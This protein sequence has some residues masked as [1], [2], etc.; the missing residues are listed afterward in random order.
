MSINKT[1]NVT[2]VGET[3]LIMH[4]DNIAWSEKIKNWQRDPNNKGDSQAGDDRSPA[5]TWIG[6]L[7]CD[8]DNTN[9]YMDSDNL[10]TML[11]EGGAKVST[12]KGKATYKAATQSGLLI[13]T[14]GSP[15][16]VNGRQIPK[17]D[18]LALEGERDFQKHEELA[19]SLG[20]EL[21]VKRAK[22]GMAKHIR[23]RPM[24]RNWKVETQIEVLDE[25]KSGITKEILQ[26][27]LDE[28]GSLCGLG[29]WRP[30][31][32]TPGKF[33]RFKAEIEEA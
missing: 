18:I 27:I 8:R 25:G 14:L 22:V 20:F 9:I 30:S 28:A 33:G 10:M 7:Y 21:L 17:K 29:D 2:L 6:S 23:V 26:R 5:W 12:G 3:P 32:R 11:R 19:R 24:F 13:T 15:F 1:Y 31:S 16:F 4:K